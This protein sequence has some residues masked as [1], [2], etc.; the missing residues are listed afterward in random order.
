M[1]LKKKADSLKEA[2]RAVERERRM[3]TAAKDQAAQLR[4]EMKDMA[5][6]LEAERTKRDKLRRTNE[7][8]KWR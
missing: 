2:K 8:L 4:A 1:A 3:A 6:S 5:K 7:R